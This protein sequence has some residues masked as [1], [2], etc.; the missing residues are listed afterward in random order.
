MIE[1]VGLRKSFHHRLIFDSLSLHVERGEAVG[2]L[3]GMAAEKQH[4]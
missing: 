2:I 4:F 1:V 3:G